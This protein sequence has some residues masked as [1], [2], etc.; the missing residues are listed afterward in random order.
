MGMWFAALLSVALVGQVF[1]GNPMR[2]DFD[3][4]EYDQTEIYKIL[5]RY[6][7]MNKTPLFFPSSNTSADYLN[8]D[9]M[10]PC[11]ERFYEIGGKYVVYWLVNG[12]VS[13]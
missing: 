1:L 2:W 3:E 7:N 13:F 4:V 8:S 9:W 6:W 12:D 10:D 11:Y 5:T